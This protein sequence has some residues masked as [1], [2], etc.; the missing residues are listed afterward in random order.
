MQTLGPE[1]KDLKNTCFDK[2]SSTNNDKTLLKAIACGNDSA[3]AELMNLYKG[4]LFRFAYRFL[5]CPHDAEE[6]AWDT[7][8]VVW[9]HASDF[10]GDTSV[11]A[12]IY[13]ICRN[14]AISKARRKR[15]YVINPVSDTIFDPSPGTNPEHQAWKNYRADILVVCIRQLPPAAREALILKHYQGL[16]YEEIARVCNCPVGTV[17]SRLNYAM[18]RLAKLVAAMDA[19]NCLGEDEP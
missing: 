14:L 9:Q 6:V 18:V 7:F 17:R 4:H 11:K 13:G 5:G 19:D 1:S 10:K 2:T 3:L 16:T 12:W 8:I 15:K